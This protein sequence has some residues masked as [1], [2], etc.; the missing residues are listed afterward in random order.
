MKF[1]DTAIDWAYYRTQSVA[2]PSYLEELQGWVK[3]MKSGS[4]DLENHKYN[5]YYAINL[6]RMRRALKMIRLDIDLFRALKKMNG[7]VEWFILSEQWCGDAA[8]CIPLFYL[9]EQAFPEKIRLYLLCRDQ[10]LELMDQFLTN[11]GRGIPKL[12]QVNDQ[13]EV[14][15]TWGPRPAPAQKLVME[16]RTQGRPYDTDLHTWYAKDKYATLQKE[17]RDLVSGYQTKRA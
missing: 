11:G 1:T 17:A 15:G 14:T 6:Q 4:L 8:Q 3:A 16:Y 5:K 12:I 7:K 2:F 13:G 9:L 10:N